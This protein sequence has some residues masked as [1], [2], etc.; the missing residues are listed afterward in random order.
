MSELRI[1][2]WDRWQSWRS[3][4]GQPPWIKI[5]REVMRKVEWVELTDAQRGQLVAMWLLAADRDGLIP[6]SPALV[7]KLCFMETAPDLQLFIEKGFIDPDA[8]VTPE[9]RQA[10]ADTTRQKRKEERR[11]EE[12]KKRED[13]PLDL[14][15]AVLDEER[16]KAIIE[17]RKK[18]RVPLSPH[19]AKLLVAQLSKCPDPN[20]AADEMLLRGWTAV[21]P[22]WLKDKFGNGVK[23]PAQQLSGGQS[24]KPFAP[25]PE[26]PQVTP[27]ELAERKAKVDEVTRL[28]RQTAERMSMK[29]KA[30]RAAH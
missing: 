4:R 2:N 5:H 19:A 13:A 18:K 30:G 24:F 23:K 6:S 28:M 20:A 27:E 3:D 15:K 26:R 8:S 29:S 12:N 1:H 14:L 22:D 7:Q 10:D 16:A 21:K 9:E 11:G 17:H 25:E